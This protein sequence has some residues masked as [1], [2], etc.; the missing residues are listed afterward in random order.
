MSENTLSGR[1]LKLH[2]KGSLHVL[3]RGRVC[4]GCGASWPCPT[5]QVMIDWATEIMEEDE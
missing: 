3:D 5:V 1:L 4:I 2:R